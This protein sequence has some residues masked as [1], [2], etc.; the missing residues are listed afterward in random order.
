[1]AILIYSLYTYYH[2]CASLIIVYNRLEKNVW[3][4]FLFMLKWLLDEMIIRVEISWGCS[5]RIELTNVFQFF[6]NMVL[7]YMDL[8]S[9]NSH[10]VCPHFLKLPGL[11][12]RAKDKSENGG[13]VIMIQLQ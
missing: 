3:M 11:N 13:E 2:N 9:Q 6:S 10:T 12:N 4:W 1:M 5:C 8:N 7:I